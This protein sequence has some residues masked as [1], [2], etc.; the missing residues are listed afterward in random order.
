M[1]LPY[2]SWAS[3]SSL[4]SSSEGVAMS[5][6]HHHTAAPALPLDQSCLPEESASATRAH[7]NT[8]SNNNNNNNSNSHHSSP[9]FSNPIPEFMES[10]ID[11]F[12]NQSMSPEHSDN[13][14]LPMNSPVESKPLI[15]HSIRPQKENEMFRTPNICRSILESSPRTP[16]PFRSALAMQEAKYGPLKLL[17]T[18]LEQQMVTSIK[19][20][21]MECAI[22][23]PP[24]KK[25]KQE[26]ESPCERSPCMQWEAQDLHTQ[27]FSPNGHAQE[28]P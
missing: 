13:D 12:L 8:S 23:Q 24:L 21:P 20:E 10:V 9:A 15:D 22:E 25:I 4:T 3:Q 19:Q 27:L 1:N 16:T 17:N 5:L 2:P 28:V 18:P 26:V 11:S 7:S 6:P 14:S